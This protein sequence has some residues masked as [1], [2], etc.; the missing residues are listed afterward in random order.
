[1]NKTIAKTSL[2]VLAS[3]LVCPSAFAAE[4]ADTA[5]QAIKDS[6]L[7]IS[8]DTDDL[9]INIEGNTLNTGTIVVS[10]ATNSAKGYTVSVSANTDHTDLRHTTISS[11]KIEAVGDNTAANAFQ[12]ATWGLST[13]A[14]IYNPATLSERNIFKTEVNGANDHNVTIGIQPAGDLAMGQYQNSLTFTAVTNSL[15][16]GTF[17]EAF[18]EI[19]IPPT[20]IQKRKTVA[21]SQTAARITL[22]KT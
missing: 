12:P 7:S 9:V 14:S 17:P 3:F 2:V 4:T 6:T 20:P 15:P 21:T 10:A 16:G 8:V 22:C 5:I 13:D 11:Q 18:E 1:M 19:G